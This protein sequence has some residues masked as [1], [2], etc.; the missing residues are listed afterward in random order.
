MIFLVI[1]FCVIMFLLVD[2]NFLHAEE[3]L[4]ILQS[5][6]AWVCFGSV[7][8]NLPLKIPLKKDMTLHIHQGKWHF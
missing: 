1:V 6:R 4:Q 8:D 3:A 5:D 7:K 2:A